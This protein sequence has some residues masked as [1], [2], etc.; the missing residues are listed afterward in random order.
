MLHRLAE[1]AGPFVGMVRSAHDELLEKIAQQCFE[2]DVFRSTYAQKVIDYIDATYHDQLE[3]LWPKFPHNAVWRRQDTYKWYGALLLVHPSKLG[4]D[5]TDDIEIIDLRMEPGK[6]AKLLD[7]QKYF[8]GYHM[9]KKHWYTVCLNGTVPLDELFL[10]IDE[11]YLL[12][13]K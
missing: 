5:G 6:L 10:R 13:V 8:P 9:N 4:L 3:F 2:P 1:T 7:N 11:S 12:A